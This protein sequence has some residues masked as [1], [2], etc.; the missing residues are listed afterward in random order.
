MK[1]TTRH[2]KTVEYYRKSVPVSINSRVGKKA[3]KLIKNE[4]TEDSW[5]KWFNNNL[6]QLQNIIDQDKIPSIERIDSVKNYCASNCIWL[7]LGLNTAFGKINGLKKELNCWRK[8]CRD[9]INEIPIV[10]QEYYKG[11]YDL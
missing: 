6:T 5:N 2:P 4:F 3:Y 11:Q 8:Y 9:H 7:P 10:L 1:K